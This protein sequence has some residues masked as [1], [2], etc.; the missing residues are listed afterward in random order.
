MQS[1]RSQAR[2]DDAGTAVLRGGNGGW[3]LLSIFDIWLGILQGLGISLKVTAYG[4]FFA[5][6]FALVFGVAQFVTTGW[7]RFLVTAVIEFWRS[8]AVVVLLFVFYYVLPVIGVTLSALTVS[9]LV[10]GLNTGGYASQAVRAGLQSL[11]AG[12]REA[13]MALGLSRPAI[14]LLIELPQALVRPVRAQR[15]IGALYGLKGHA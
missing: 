11:P 9:A 6:P 4:L 8:S 13:G 1:R 12:Q 10:L 15:V 3:R 7:T 5:V 2:R 14:L